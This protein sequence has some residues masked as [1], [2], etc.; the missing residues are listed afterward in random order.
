MAEVLITDPR[1]ATLDL[2]NREG[3]LSVLNRLS[4][5]GDLR[6]G[7]L[8]GGRASSGICRSRRDGWRRYVRLFA[9]GDDNGDAAAEE[10]EAEDPADGEPDDPGRASALGRRVVG[11]LHACSPVCVAM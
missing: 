8:L 5:T 10:E 7:L 11:L 4:D 9:G 1:G 3:E 6:I 2:G